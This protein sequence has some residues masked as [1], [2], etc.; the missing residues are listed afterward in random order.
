MRV[1]KPCQSQSI[2]SQPGVRNQW[3]PFAVISEPVNGLP[4]PAGSCG[5]NCFNA[6]DR[7]R[8]RVRPWR[9]RAWASPARPSRSSSKR[10][11]DPALGLG[12]DMAPS[13][14]EGDGAWREMSLWACLPAGPLERH[15]NGRGPGGVKGGV[16]EWTCKKGLL[17][18]LGGWQFGEASACYLIR[19]EK[20]EK[21]APVDVRLQEKFPHFSS[22]RAG[23][24]LNSV[25]CRLC[26]LRLC[27]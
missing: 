26:R 3:T 1:L 4:G 17:P 23:L 15:Q 25:Q 21:V 20:P 18:F 19:C 8:C 16:R 7:A 24:A 12:G 13:I 27:S 14:V 6:S 10:T 5:V 9:G 22:P 2:F 11:S